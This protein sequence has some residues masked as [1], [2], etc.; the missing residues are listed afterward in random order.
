[1]VK[2]QEKP[3]LISPVPTQLCQIQTVK[4]A[5]LPCRVGKGVSWLRQ[6]NHYLLVH[7]MRCL[8][9]NRIGNDRSQG[10][11][12]CRN[13]GQIRPDRYRVFTPGQPTDIPA[14]LTDVL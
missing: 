7:V 11:A 3:V 14:C 13:T 1:M 6:L 4:T 8:T 12:A 2:M 5:Q 10:I 9:A